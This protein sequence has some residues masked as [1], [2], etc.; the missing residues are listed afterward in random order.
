MPLRSIIAVIFAIVAAAVCVRLGLWQLDRLDERRAHNATVLQRVDADPVALAELG[1]DT[2]A[3]R[4]RR[5]R[6]SGEYDFEHELALTGRSRDG[7]PGVHLITP[8]RVPGSERAVLVNRGWVYSPDAATVD[9]AKWRTSPEAE[10][11]AYVELFGE[12]KAGQARSASNPRA[13]RWIDSAAVAGIVPY[14]VAPYY[15][16]LLPDSGEVRA[17]SEGERRLPGREAGGAATAGGEPTSPG[18][19][20]GRLTIPDLGEGPHFGYAVQWFIFAAVAV[21]GVTVL[22]VT[23]QKARSR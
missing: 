10:G 7:S 22:L 13:V 20:P 23:E 17:G 16:V 18:D 19:A 5:V 4:Y 1:A 11:V 2:A 8:L 15:V 21:I 14:P 3:I 12:T 6:L 9:L